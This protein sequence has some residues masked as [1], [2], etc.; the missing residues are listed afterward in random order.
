MAEKEIVTTV[1]QEVPDGEVE[2]EAELR[3]L[4]DDAREGESRLRTLAATKRTQGKIDIAEVYEELAPLFGLTAD[5]TATLTDEVMSIE[6]DLEELHEAAAAGVPA[7][8]ALLRED[9]DKYLALFQLYAQLLAQLAPQIPDGTGGADQREALARLTSMTEGMR[10]FTES[11]VIEVE[12]DDEDE[13][14]GEGAGDDDD[15]DDA[16]DADDE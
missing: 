16:D 11:I 7:Q 4:F 5:L 3:S 9:A 14:D 13:A 10:E 6:E 2:I 15:D 12:D 8:S 1:G